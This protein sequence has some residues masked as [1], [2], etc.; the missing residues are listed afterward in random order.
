MHINDG[1]D[2]TDCHDTAKLAGG[3][4]AGLDTPGFE[5]DPAL[6]LRNDLNYD[7]GRQTCTFGS[8]SR[9]H[10][11]DTHRSGENW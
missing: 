11:T 1:F 6:T 9:C 10:N 3:H 8:L 7:T 5:G 4:F 2:C